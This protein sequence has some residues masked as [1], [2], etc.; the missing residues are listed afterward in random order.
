MLGV[1]ESCDNVC[2]C[3]HNVCVCAARDG[4]LGLKLLTCC[5]VGL[6]LYKSI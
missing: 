6:K 2:V 3:V 5:L 1:G 4:E